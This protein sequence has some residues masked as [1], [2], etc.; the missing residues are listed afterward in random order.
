MIAPR[1][2]TILPIFAKKSRSVQPRRIL[3][4]EITPQGMGKMEAGRRLIAA[5]TRGAISTC[6]DRQVQSGTGLM[7]TPDLGRIGVVGFFEICCTPPSCANLE[8]SSNAKDCN[9]EYIMDWKVVG[10]QVPVAG[11]GAVSATQPGN[12]GEQ[13]SGTEAE[14]GR[15]PASSGS[16]G[17]RA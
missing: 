13:V 2:I 9:S 5:Y 15:D 16:P 12:E 14:I 11:C 6:G 1:K 10:F 4:Y 7:E 3:G 8:T 17:G